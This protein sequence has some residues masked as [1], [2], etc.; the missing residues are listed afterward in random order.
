MSAEKQSHYIL[1]L[2]DAFFFSIFTLSF[3]KK[4]V[5]ALIV[6]HPYFYLFFAIL[7]QNVITGSIILVA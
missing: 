5:I 3:F 7:H 1:P 4:H 2:A 6:I